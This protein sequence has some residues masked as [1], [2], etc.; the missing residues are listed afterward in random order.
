MSAIERTSATCAPPEFY[1]KI[2]KIAA[3][4]NEKPKFKSS[5]QPIKKNVTKNGK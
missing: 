1:I 5:I 3:L 4:K 2:W